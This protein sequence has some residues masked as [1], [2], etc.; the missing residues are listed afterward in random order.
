MWCPNCQSKSPLIA[1]Q[2]S[3]LFC[4]RCQVEV[5]NV[6]P[7]T[8]SM[9]SEHSS[10]QRRQPLF[11]KDNLMS[12]ESEN[13]EPNIIP[14]FAKLDQ[15][16]GEFQES[17]LASEQPLY[18]FDESHTRR[19]IATS[20]DDQS[21]HQL[22]KKL[23]TIPSKFEQSDS[24]KTTMAIG[25]FF[26]GQSLIVWSF[27]TGNVMGLAAGMVIATSAVGVGYLHLVPQR[28]LP[29]QNTQSKTTIA[30]INNSSKNANTPQK[31]ESLPGEWKPKS[32]R[33]RKPANSHDGKLTSPPAKK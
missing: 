22:I 26:A 7:A 25:L 4:A 31:S 2:H 23:P 1:V 15:D 14:L 5:E 17:T 8:E 21:A 28:A 32:K 19:A 9:D 3:G 24:P 11:S 16:G 13:A 33:S 30:T 29:K 10:S 27:F 12:Y 18:R 20:R 6:P